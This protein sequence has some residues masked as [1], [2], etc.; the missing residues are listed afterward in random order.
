[1]TKIQFNAEEEILF[2]NF[3]GEIGLFEMLSSYRNL[4]ESGQLSEGSCVLLD[5][6]SAKFNFKATEVPIIAFELNKFV[7]R[8]SDTRIAAVYSSPKETAFGQL[9]EYYAGLA[10]YHYR[11][12]HTSESACDWLRLTFFPC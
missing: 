9:I 10:K 4:G 2:V 3:F 7:Q 12:F 11:V 1:M 6:T 8:F 5:F